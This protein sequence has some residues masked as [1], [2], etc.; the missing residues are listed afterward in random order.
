MA[1]TIATHNGS[2]VARDHNIR[3]KKVVSKEKHIDPNGIHE[4]WIDEKPTQAYERLFRKAVDDYNIKQTRED[5]KIKNYYSDICKDAKKHPVYE[6]IVA[7]GNRE[8]RVDEIIGKEIMREFV[9]GWQERNPNLELIGAYYHADEEGVPHVHC[10]YIPVAHGYS[11]GMETQ[12]GLV[13]ALG[14]MGFHKQGKATAQIQWEQKENNALETLCNARNLTIEHP[15]IENIKHLHTDEYKAKKR[16]TEVIQEHERYVGDIKTAK[17]IQEIDGKPSLI[18]KDQITIKRSDYDS[19]KKTATAV[20]NVLEE[21]ELLDFDMTEIKKMKQATAKAQNHAEQLEKEKLRIV[22]RQKE[23]IQKHLT[24]QTQG[25]TNKLQQVLMEQL[26]QIGRDEKR[27]YKRME[28]F[29]RD[30]KYSDG[31]NGLDRF[32]RKEQEFEKKK[33]DELKKNIATSLAMYER[34]VGDNISKDMEN[35]KLNKHMNDDFEL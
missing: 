17:E 27:K 21:Q 22:E 24:Q 31:S 20:E 1:Y 30:I 13:K 32:N 18:H 14:E 3:N 35:I 11:R 28:D 23:I 33:N 15:R 34:I 19:L 5:R 29:L 8:N 10:D 6:M 26:E 12:T 4:T 25:I 2:A 7:I 9:D 16:L